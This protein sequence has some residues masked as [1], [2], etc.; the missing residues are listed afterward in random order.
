MIDF[1]R[2]N[3]NLHIILDCD[4]VLLDWL[5]AFRRFVSAIENRPIEGL[6]DSWDMSGWLGLTPAASREMVV[7]F[8]HSSQFEYLEACPLAVE[9]VSALKEMGHR[10]TV[11]TSCSDNPLIVARRKINLERVFGDVFEQVICLPLGESKKKWLGILE[12][13]IWI[14]DNYDHA[15]AGHDNGHKSFMVRRS[16]NRSRETP[17]DPLVT[18]VDDLRPIIS[19]LS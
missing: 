18:W 4:D 17:G 16:H 1:H 13:G 7:G 2:Q 12:R 9:N 5:G 3:R 14:E 6:P 19:L 8:N 10:L 15:I 11:L